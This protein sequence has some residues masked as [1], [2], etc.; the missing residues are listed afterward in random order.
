MTTLASQTPASE[1][2]GSYY[3]ASRNDMTQ[4]PVADGNIDVDICV[5]GAGF[6]GL[7]TAL[8][9]LEKGHS[10]TIL[11]ASRVGWGASGRNGGQMINGLNAGI[12]KVHRLY[13]AEAAATVASVM[14]TGGGIIRRIATDYRIDCDIRDHAIYAACTD[15]HLRELEQMRTLWR[16]YGI[17]DAELLDH[18]DIQR[19]IDTRVYRGGMLDRSAGHLHPLNLALGEA[20][21]IESMGGNI[22]EQS[23][24]EEI[25]LPRSQPGAAESST[26][27]TIT[28]R[29][30]QAT[31]RCSRLV[32]C[33]NAYL[34]K[35][36]PELS[37]RVLPVS[38]Q[39]VATEPLEATLAASLLPGGACVEDTR[40]IL[41][42]YRISADNRLLFGGGSLYG[43]REP[44]DIAATL[45]PN[46]EKVFPQL[47][48]IPLE[49][50]WSGN[51][52]LSYTRVPQLGRL[53]DNVYF[54]HG[55]SGHGVTGTHLFGR[56]LAE[57]IDGQ[58]DLFDFFSA[59]KWRSFPGGQRYG[60]AYSTVGAWWYGLRDRLG[61]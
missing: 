58:S 31:V 20:R 2:I 26:S 46:L 39:I 3:A 35:A 14:Q 47:T 19:H 12:D 54:A 57:A 36:L 25:T 56:I 48:G 50:A 45:R 51:F 40:Y 42:Y 22:F 11:E 15:K 34:G 59:L 41:D 17:D 4:R 28:V 30:A 1:H 32:I 52:A 5:I 49:F 16:Q 60:A 23:R 7:S 33:G 43:G 8:H 27:E 61:W 13:G 44:A 6:S 10:V 37:K 9:L 55:Y 38:T 18:N 29:T 24:V 53:H 21:A